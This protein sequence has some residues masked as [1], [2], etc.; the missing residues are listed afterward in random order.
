MVLDITLMGI[1]LEQQ[2]FL[3]LII[4]LLFFGYR[5][6]KKYTQKMLIIS[7]IVV[8]ALL[9]IAFA[10]PYT[11]TPHTVT[12]T[13]PNVIVVSDETA[14][15]DLFDNAT[16][17]RI[18]DSIKEVTPTAMR[19]IS[20]NTSGIGDSLVQFSQGGD[21]IVL[22]SDL[23]N[24]AGSDLIDAIYFLS[25]I[26]STVYAID[27]KTRYDDVA[28]SIIGDKN[29]I[30]GSMNSFSIM[31]SQTADRATYRLDVLIDDVS[32][33]SETITQ[34]TP[35][36]LISRDHTFATPGTHTVKAMI[37]NIAIDGSTDHYPDN[38]VFYKSIQVVDKPK[39]L[40]VSGVSSP[41][42]QTLAKSYNVGVSATPSNLPVYDAVILDNMAAS[43]ISP[44][45]DGLSDYVS[46]GNGL[47]VVGGASAYEKGGYLNSVFETMLPVESKA[48]VSTGEDVAVII[49][50]DISGSTSGTVDIEKRLALDVLG[51]LSTKDDIGVIAFNDQ[52]HIVSPMTK[53]IY[54]STLEDK[55]SRLTHSGS[56]RMDT[57]L[58]E[59]QTMFGGYPGAKNVI[60]ISDG[61]V[62]GM[63]GRTL[64]LA[65]QMLADGTTVYTVGVGGLT[66]EMFMREV[67]R[68]GGGIYYK[69][70]EKDRLNIIFGDKADI[71]SG[72]GGYNVVA[73]NPNHFITQGLNLS[74]Q[75]SGFNGVTQ[76]TSA[77]LL[78]STDTGNPIVTVSQY[79][80]GRVVAFSTDNGNG[81]SLSLYGGNNA[82]LLARMVNWAIG[83][84]RQSGDVSISADDTWFGTPT[85]V[86]VEAKSK[87]SIK[88][89]GVAL[90]LSRVGEAA[91]QAE[92]E[93]DTVGTHDV[94]GYGVSVNYPLEFKDVGINK[95]LFNV[96]NS[97]GGGVYSEEEA[98]EFLFED[99]KRKSTR[100]VNEP[101]NM[102]M[103]FLLAAL[104]IF[105]GEVLMR[106]LMQ[107]RNVRKGSIKDK[108]GQSGG[109]VDSQSGEDFEESQE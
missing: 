77:Q 26:N 104:I 20:G 13:E 7:R 50:I 86:Y 18:Y 103:P 85:M 2:V 60:I 59:A 6:Y 51:G 23:N 91:Y 101:R 53:G 44:Y 73:L 33:K 70:D 30:V 5:G 55:I 25:S 40:L 8:L 36:I 31:V 97:T 3:L 34:D 100:I 90:E 74:A 47:I 88:V 58:I 94:S 43:S 71:S 46:E 81:W 37:S 96:I 82:N 14:S 21:N 62:S 66:A 29:V 69:L 61:I 109:L 45:V 41:L 22:V 57:A 93:L 35:Q 17:T 95:E 67:A 87:P 1:R 99:M 9:I 108:D 32:V 16:A 63:G 92:V 76:K 56:T 38:N 10:G 39:I 106:R 105:L 102:K 68:R 4:P 12:D 98:K 78:V 80:L 79:G 89:D 64:E 42:S 49:I 107:M 11:V 83:T 75:L 52:A 15:M 28:V 19:T 72:G 65:D 48:S 84:P 54:K 27:Q 24:N